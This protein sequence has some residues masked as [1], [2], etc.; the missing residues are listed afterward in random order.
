ME[1]ETVATLIYLPWRWTWV[2]SFTPRQL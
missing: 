1:S 2:V